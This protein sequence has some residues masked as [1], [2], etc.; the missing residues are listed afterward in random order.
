MILSVIWPV[1]L[2]SI[3]IRWLSGL[4]DSM[5]LELLSFY[6]Y[7]C[8]FLLLYLLIH[9]S[10]PLRHRWLRQVFP[11]RFGKIPPIDLLHFCWFIQFI[12]RL[13]WLSFLIWVLCL[14]V[15]KAHKSSSL[16]LPIYGSIRLLFPCHCHTT[17]T[18]DSYITINLLRLQWLLI[19]MFL[20]VDH[21]SVLFR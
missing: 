3:R 15:L 13:C 12:I 17:S 20:L 18:D 8:T 2:V 11:F 14:K 1:V 16:P 19:K 6:C 10:L 5:A 7:C 21:P 4:E 9:K